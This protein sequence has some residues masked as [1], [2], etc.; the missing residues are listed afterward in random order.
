MD[1]I[2]QRNSKT[3]SRFRNR[4]KTEE[5]STI[6]KLPRNP[7]RASFAGCTFNH[8]NTK[9]GWDN[10]KRGFQGKVSEA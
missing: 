7:A 2:P 6:G 8:Q 4:N 9:S 10:A 1:S 5:K 3:R